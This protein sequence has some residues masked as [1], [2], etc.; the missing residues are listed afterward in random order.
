MTTYFQASGVEVAIWIPPLVALAVS[1]CTSMGGVSGAFLLLPFQVSVLGYTAPS[2]SAT[3]Q[4]F[5][6]VAIPGGVWRYVR[7]GRMIWPLCLIVLAGSLPGTLVGALTRITYLR[8]PGLFKV[9]VALVLLYVGG[10]M[11]RDL[12]RAQARSQKSAVVERHFQTLARHQRQEP[13]SPDQLPAVVVRTFTSR[14][15]SYE[16]CGERFEFSTIGAVALSFGV[17]I[18]GGIY[19]IGGGAVIA[20]LLV[21]F[22][23]LPVYTIAGTTLL[24]TFVTSVAGV[25]IYQG[26]ALF[27][28]TQSIAPDW[29]LGL[30]FGVG[31]LAG[32]YLGARCQKYIPSRAIKW[33][34][35]AVILFIAG[36]YL[37][38]L[39][40]L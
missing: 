40:L 33:M 5:N 2:V 12:T 15:T 21:A 11:I 16:F 9:F 22:F 39:R 38:D 4:V 13:M 20:P 23:G 24:S 25:G 8:D 18:V 34:L 1:F 10:R 6:V 7:E 37:L 32:M 3:N 28:P 27:H 35:S 29:P 30:L 31:G 19:G 26:L 14:R 17:G 36:K